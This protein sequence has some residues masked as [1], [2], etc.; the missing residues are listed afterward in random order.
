MPDMLA[1]DGRSSSR[2]PTRVRA[3]RF[4]A[5]AMW[6]TVGVVAPM[7]IGMMMIGLVVNVAQ[8]GFKPTAKKLKPDFGR[9]NLFK[10]IKKHG[11]HAGVV[12]ARQGAREDR[13]ARR[14][15][16]AGVRERDPHAHERWTARA[17]SSIAGLHR[18]RRR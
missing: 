12:G 3:D 9:L 1:G 7:L 10:G 17:R 18:D 14:R 11:R 6:K 2:T 8:V 16:V 4:A 15:R 13:A 5:T